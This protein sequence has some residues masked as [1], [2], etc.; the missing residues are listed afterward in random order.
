MPVP[1]IH[2]YTVIEDSGCSNMARVV[3]NDAAVIT[4]ATI[5][6]IKQHVFDLDATDPTV[7]LSNTALTVANVVFD[8]LQTDARWTKDSTGYNFRDDVDDTILSTGGNRYRFEY[9]FEPSSGAKFHVLFEITALAITI[10]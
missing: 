5:S 1:I 3:G 4:I 9:V 8:T 7:D 6:T 2:H 10:T